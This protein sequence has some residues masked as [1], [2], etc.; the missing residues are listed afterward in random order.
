MS[1]QIEQQKKPRHIIQYQKPFK[2]DPS[3]QIGLKN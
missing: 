2:K 3:L 1:T